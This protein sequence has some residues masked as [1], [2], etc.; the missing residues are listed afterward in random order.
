MIYMS[1]VH[2]ALKDLTQWVDFRGGY[3]QPDTSEEETFE[4]NA[5]SVGIAFIVQ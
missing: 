5:C 4:L 2:K 1:K 3:G